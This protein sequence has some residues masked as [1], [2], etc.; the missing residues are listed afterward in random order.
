MGNQK[1]TLVIHEAVPIRGHTCGFARL[2]RPNART[3]LPRTTATRLRPRHSAGP[4]NSALSAFIPRNASHSNVDF[5][6]ARMG[7]GERRVICI[8]GADTRSA[9]QRSRDALA[10]SLSIIRDTFV[11]SDISRG[12]IN[13]PHP[14][15]PSARTLDRPG[16]LQLQFYFNYRAP[17][18]HHELWTP[19]CDWRA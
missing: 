10:G 5:T 14:P 16:R 13:S 12:T 8:R 18:R 7:F 19:R 15:V 3:R 4:Y 1:Y 17:H 2:S 11:S 6:I 9:F